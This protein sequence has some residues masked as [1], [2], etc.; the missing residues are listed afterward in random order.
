MKREI[1]SVGKCL[2]CG[3]I[4]EFKDHYCARCGKE[5]RGWVVP[6]EN[7]CGNC[8]AYLKEG[9]SYCRICGTRRG[10]G[11]YKPYQN[12]M[13]TIYGPMPVRREHICPVC[14]FKWDNCV[15]IDEDKYCPKCGSP[16]NP[17]D[18]VVYPKS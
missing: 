13:Q 9:D 3:N 2:Y 12:I 1:N 10:D 15:M 11:E 14:G 17:A 6:D 18:P 7:Q 8:N 16:L 5:N 4:I